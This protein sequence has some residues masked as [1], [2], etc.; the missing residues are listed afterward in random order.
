MSAEDLENYETDM[1]LQLYREYKDIA[2]QFSY[3]VET[4]RGRRGAHRPGGARMTEPTMPVA[5]LPAYA[6]GSLG[7]ADR[8]RVRAHLADCARC[9][10]EL[11]AWQAIAAAAP[12]RRRAGPAAAG[13]CAPC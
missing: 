6:A 5:V 9:R 4:E 7:D 3:V 13:W 2:A 8:D 12:G 11:A 10:A 1:E